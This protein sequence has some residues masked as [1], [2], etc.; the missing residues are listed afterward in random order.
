MPVLSSVLPRPSLRPAP[1][2]LL[3]YA[4][5]LFR[6]SPALFLSLPRHS[7]SHSAG[8]LFG[9]VP[10]LAPAMH[11]EYLQRSATNSAGEERKRKPG[12]GEQY[13]VDARKGV[14]AKCERQR[15]GS[16]EWGHRHSKLEIAGALL[17]AGA[18]HCPVPA[19]S[20]ALRRRSPH[21]AQALFLHY[22]CILPRATSAPS[23]VLCSCSPQ[24]Y[25]GT[26]LC[27]A[28][29]LS[30]AARPSFTLGY[31]GALRR[32]RRYSL[33]F[34]ALPRPSLAFFPTLCQHLGTPWPLHTTCGE[35]AHWGA[36]WW[37]RLQC[38]LPQSN[39]CLI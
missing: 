26:Q 8:T 24:Q 19:I 21:P 2:L 20:S 10:G 15:R 35:A 3:H 30:S 1:L 23:P 38:P 39:Y 12:T 11:E 13:A 18:I 29:A 33:C 25:T 6:T 7:V 5:A 17:C 27:T 36:S 37:G 22:A 9:A 16:A 32:R 28:T 31:A 4:C 34:A 14:P